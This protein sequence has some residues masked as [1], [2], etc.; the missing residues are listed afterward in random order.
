MR[1]TL[2]DSST[3]QNFGKVGS[4]SFTDAL[5]AA[6]KMQS[7]RRLSGFLSFCSMALFLFGMAANAQISYLTPGSN[8]TQ[9]FNNRY[10]TVPGNNVVVTTSPLPAGWQFVEAGAN[11]NT[12]LRNDNGASSTGD[13]FFYGSTGSNERALGSYASGSLTSQYGAVFTNNTGATLTEFTI[14]YT[15]EQWR[16]GGNSSAVF[17]TLTFA[18]AINSSSVTSGTFVNVTNLDFTA[19]VN[20]TSAD[21]ATDGNATNRRT[22]KTYTVT[23]I[24]WPAGQNLCIRWTDINDPG[25]DD[26]LAVDDLTFSAVGSTDPTIETTG[27]LA[28]VNTTYGTPS[29]TPRSYTVSGTNLGTNTL[30]IT[31]PT[32]FEISKN[33]IAGTY[34]TSQ[35]LTPSSGAVANTTIYVRLAATTL[36]GT[37]TG[38]ITHVSGTASANKAVV[39][40][41]VAPKAITVSNAV[42]QDKIYDRTTTATIAGATANGLV[43]GDAITVSGNGNFLDFNAADDKSVVAALVLAGTHASSYTLTQPTGLIADI[44]P[45]AL[46]LD[47]ISIG[48]KIY[49]GTTEAVFTAT[50]QGVVSPDEVLLNATAF[51]TSASAGNSVPVTSTSTI[52]GADSANYTLTQPS[53][54]AGQISAK[55]LTIEN[56]VAQNKVYD[57]NTNA[58]LT[59]TLA[60][61]IAPDEVTLTLQG[62]FASPE[63]GLDIAVTST[64]FISG[65]IANYTL[66]QP[67]GLT[68][69]ISGQAL[70]DQTITFNALADVVYGDANFNLTATSDSGLQVDYSSSDENIATVSGNVV[71]IHNAGTTTITATQ[72]GDLTYDMATP[73]ARTLTVLPKALTVLASA[74]DKVYDATSTAAISGTLQGIV[75]SDVVTFIG[76]GIFASTNVGTNIEVLSNSTIEGADVANYT[77]T[78]PTN[79]SADITPKALAVENAVASNK[80]YDTTTAAIIVGG[81][82][83]GILNND[84]VTLANFVGSFASANVAND[85]SVNANFTLEGASAAN[86]SVTQPSDLFADITAFEVNLFGLTAQDKQYDRLTTATVSGT[87]VLDGVFAGDDVT[88]SG[89]PVANFDN[90]NVGTQKTVIVTGYTL[91]GAQAA[92]YVL[93]QPADVFADVTAKAVTVLNASAD[94][95][96]F[97]G[98]TDATITGTLSGVISPDVVTLVGTGTFAQSGVGSGIA[99]TSTATLA[100]NDGLNYVIDPQPTGLTANILAA[101]VALA[102]WTYQP[103]QGATTTPT[104]NVGTGTSALV[105]SMTGAGT[106]TGMDTATGCGSQTSGTNAW[107]ISSANPGSANESSGARFSTSTSGYQDIKVTWEQRSSGTSVNTVR[108]QYTTNGTAWTN[109]TMTEANTTYC[110]GTLNNGRFE[111]SAQSDQFRRISV[112][113][114]AISGINNNPNFG[115]RIV[116]AHYQNSGQFRQTST[117]AS[118]ASAGTWRFDNV[119][120]EA[121]QIPGPSSAAISG[122]VAICAGQS[123]NLS[124]AIVDGTAPYTVV[125]NNGTNN[126]TVNNYASGANIA[127]APSATTT[128]TL[129]SVT[130][131]T[132]QSAGTLSGSATV[133]INPN[134]DF[135][136]DAD[137]DGYGAGSLVSVCAVDANTPPAGYSLNNLDCNDALAAVNPGATEVPFNGIDDDCDGTIDE[138]SQIFSQVLP[139]QCGTTLT[140]ISS[141]VGA[142]SFGTPVDG[143]RFRIVNVATGAVQTIDRVTPNFQVSL[144]PTFDY[145]ATYSVSVQLRRNGT[146]LN[147]YGPACQISTPAILD[148]GGAA[149]VNPSQCGIVLPAIS[150]LIAT[151]SLPNVTAYRFRITD[152][153]T[154]Q[155]QVLERSTNWF[156]L[157][158]LNNYLYGRTYAIEVSVKTSGSF[159]GYGQPCSVT[160]PTV[161]QLTNCGATIA[162]AGSVVATTSLNRVTSY[163]FQLTN[164]STFETVF[165]T[166]SQNYFTFNN[167]AGYVPGATY[168]V[169]VAVMTAGAW[170]DFG[171]SCTIV[172]PGGVTREIVKG[173]ETSAPQVAFRAVAY[174][175]PYAQGFALDMDS[176]SEEKVSVKVYD[177]IGKLV[178]NREISFEAIESAQFGENY[179]SGVYNVVVN[180]GANVTTLRVIKR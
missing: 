98:T 95:K 157:T 143:Y 17:N 138:G 48:N 62:Q 176:S 127:V 41:T 102:N 118:V 25:N 52:Y 137:F 60:G 165:V 78:Q 8:Y 92:N 3:N 77:L 173:E 66:T 76:N 128:Y 42:A 103:L 21:V 22:T 106:A 131:A 50:L 154:N 166:R 80:V 111:N 86:Y 81:N 96:N 147:Y 43:N 90:K 85:I 45:K 33:G 59:G 1:S 54:L 67:T 29:A 115:V 82:L 13:T 100:G 49:D 169:S 144:L 146:W 150:T 40:S 149:A 110:L 117:P 16:D 174:P 55:T 70:I 164:L 112:D 53:G 10:T 69:N 12:T 71:T 83:V 47:A 27:T 160:A 44:S 175:N 24:S 114:S 91:V 145:A 46:T 105:G 18:Y 142:V 152:T 51:F 88:V 30:T 135:Y 116:A 158:M 58:Q 64:S 121:T 23:G 36:A 129:V 93:A 130:D 57:G 4:L 32:G 170:S 34:A 72:N 87:P 19:L 159:S 89:T 123:V 140:S 171:E 35:T 63:I 153:A 139:S 134:F 104:P 20:N 151:T 56:A 101:P 74:S 79:L 68:A 162:N 9:D 15:G 124:V 61:V 37:C 94:D 161:P 120:I 163:Q 122:S 132:S 113:L 2:P 141:Y 156:A 167:V 14:T 38:N 180:Q 133:T 84:E 136:V 99:V 6:F 65:D 11:S 39:S 73:V 5:S 109:F 119:K 126:V 107:A 75:G 177:M 97:D 148:Q 178:E 179:P 31:A 168:V 7:K 155:Q 26:G 172:A 108:L 28:A 125:Y